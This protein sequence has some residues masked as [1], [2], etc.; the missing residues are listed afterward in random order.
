MNSSNPRRSG[1]LLLIYR[2]YN[3]KNYRCQGASMN[4]TTHSVG[5]ISQ[6][7]GIFKSKSKKVSSS[8][9]R[10]R[11]VGRSAR[12]NNPA[13]RYPHRS[14]SISSEH[15][16]CACEAVEIINGKRF[17]L[18]EIPPLPLPDCTTPNCKCAY[19]RHKDRRGISSNR[20]AL[21]SLNT[22]LHAIGGDLERRL[23]KGRRASD[24]P[25]FASEANLD[26]A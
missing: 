14:A 21:F 12:S 13:N 10:R 19:V 5:L 9:A 6:A 2:E 18:N 1:L 23:V 15:S 4:K 25:S 20:R 24:E 7:L 26:I 16:S 22:D 11:G 8:T 17:L 3:Y